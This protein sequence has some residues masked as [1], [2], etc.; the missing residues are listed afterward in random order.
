MLGVAASNNWAIAPQRTRNGKSILA[1]DT[2]LPL[3]MPS[4]WN[5]MRRSARRSSRPQAS[6]SPACPPWS[7]AST[8]SWPGHDHGHGRQPGPLPEKV[9]R[10]G[11][12]LYYLADGKWQ[13][14]IERNE[15]FFIKGERPI[16]ETLYETRHG[17]LLNSVLGQRKHPLQPLEMK[18]GLGIALKTAQFENDQTLDAFFDLSR[19][20][21]VEQASEATRSIRA[22]GLNLLTAD[23]QHIAWQ[24]TGRYPNRRE[25][26]GLMPSPAG[27]ALRLGRFRRP[28][29][30]PL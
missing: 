8:A 26:R 3:A 12:R 14:A 13:P 20:Q 7:P 10:E 1:N 17:P 30:A 5:F 18:S 2:H 9:K 29:A 25:G 27:T 21:S 11:N 22:I 16:R 23:A 6:P 24:V 4:Y 19:A 28:H 15:T